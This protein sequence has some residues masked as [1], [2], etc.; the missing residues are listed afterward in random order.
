MT[1]KNGLR[2][3]RFHKNGDPVG[4]SSGAEG[5][6]VVDATDAVD[7]S[8]EKLK[9]VVALPYFYMLSSLPSMRWRFLLD[10]PGLVSLPFEGSLLVSPPTRPGGA[11]RN[12]LLMTSLCSRVVF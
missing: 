2:P 3:S 9:D 5:S 8:R 6:T 12:A 4:H 10:A 1:S 11:A 7:A